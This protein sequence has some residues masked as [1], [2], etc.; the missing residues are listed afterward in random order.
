VSAQVLVSVVMG[1]Y[2][3]ERELPATLDSIFSQQDV[4][5]ECI[6]VDDGSTDATWS[7]LQQRAANEPRLKIIQLPHGGLTKALIR[8]CSAAQGK[9]IA[10]IDAGDRFLP[11]RLA[12]QFQLLEKYPD[13][14]LVSCGTRF[15]SAEG[16]WL[17]SVS[18]HPDELSRGLENCDVKLV[19]GP[20]H[21]GSTMFRRDLYSRVGGYR[22]VFRVAQDLDLWM[23]LFEKSK[24][25]AMP[26][27]LYESRIFPDSISVGKRSSQLETAKLILKGA[28]C[29]RSGKPEP[30]YFVEIPQK[31]EKGLVAEE[32][33]VARY[34]YF[35]GGCLAKRNNQAATRYF[36]RAWRQS[37]MNLKYGLKYLSS[38]IR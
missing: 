14:G 7:I 32:L 15:M 19:R 35:V 2:N 24:V 1:V 25:L 30:D 33:S 12:Q 23:R 22:E 31:N 10:R 20:S 26:E 17:Y 3:G 36:R 27:I 8:G 5:F 4:E 6:V 18:Q 28:R 37:P 9:Y 21:H 11:G 29:R 34:D 38:L 16:E 13:V